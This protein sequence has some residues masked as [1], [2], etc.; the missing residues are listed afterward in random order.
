MQTTHIYLIRH[1]ESEG[2]RV[3]SFLGH[4][5]L[6]LTEKGHAQAERTAEYLDS[7]SVDKIYSSDLKRAYN[8]AYHT[9]KKKGMEIITS[10]K[11]RE[12][13][14]G[15]WENI[16]FDELLVEYKEEYSLFRENIGLAR[17]TGGE[18]V[19]ELQERFVNELKRIAAENEGKTVFVFT[20]ATPIRATKAAFDGLALE[21]M[22]SVPWASNASV[23][24]V[25]CS[26]GE[27]KVVAYGINDFMGEIATAL[28]KTV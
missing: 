19:A 24:H 5:D 7:V 17:C 28:P 10:E 18:S 2:N 1:G 25:E 21:E 12:I 11:L 23:T 22:Q 9:A 27:F 16:A 4:S 20:H 8:T 26:D 14:A 15:E 13:Y 6:D 3:R